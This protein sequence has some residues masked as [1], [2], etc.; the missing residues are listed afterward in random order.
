MVLKIINPF[1]G[2]AIAS[3]WDEFIR[4]INNP[5]VVLVISKAALGCGV[6]V[7][8]P[9]GCDCTDVERNTNKMANAIKAIISGI[10]LNLKGIPAE[11]PSYQ[12]VARQI[13]R[14]SLK[15][16]FLLLLRFK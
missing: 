16:M 5:P 4:G 11:A 1:V 10:K 6:V 9:T 12:P 13:I 8:I 3:L 7:P 2:N 15:K 14:M